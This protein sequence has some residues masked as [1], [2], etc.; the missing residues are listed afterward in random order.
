MPVLKV[1]QR[2]EIVDLLGVKHV[3]GSSV[4]PQTVS[5]VGTI[6]DE[7][8]VVGAAVTWDF[9]VTGTEEPLTDF[10]FLF[11]ESDL[12]GVMVELTT[13]KGAE[14]GKVVSTVELKAGKPLMLNSD[15]SWANYTVDFAAGT[16]DVI[17]QI[18]IHNPAGNANVRAVLVT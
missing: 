13:D 7:V 12:D 18:R 3:G 4:T 10:D 15:G 5:V 11:I 14:V 6:K 1:W 9:W 16:L 8:K 17:D 2:F